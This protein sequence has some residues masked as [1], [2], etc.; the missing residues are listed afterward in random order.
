T[1]V[2]DVKVVGGKEWAR[3]GS[4]DCANGR[5]DGPLGPALIAESDDHGPVGGKMTLKD[6]A[7]DMLLLAEEAEIHRGSGVLYGGVPCVGPSHG[8]GDRVSGVDLHMH[9]SAT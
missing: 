3:S 5:E 7:G 9:V 1:E 6:R 4:E 8:Y 2:L